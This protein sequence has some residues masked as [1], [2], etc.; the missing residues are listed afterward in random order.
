MAA[1]HLED[2]QELNERAEKLEQEL[3]EI[4]W[5]HM[6]ALEV[7][8]EESNK[9]QKVEQ[10]LSEVS[11]KLE[12]MDEATEN[13]LHLLRVFGKYLIENWC[14]FYDQIKRLD[15]HIFEAL[16]KFK[17]LP[18]NELEA[19]GLLWNWFEDYQI[20]FIK[21]MKDIVVIKDNKIVELRFG[22]VIL[23]IKGLP[24]LTKVQTL[25][26]DVRLFLCNILSVEVVDMIQDYC[27][28]RLFP[29]LLPLIEPKGV[30]VL[31]MRWLNLRETW[32]R[33]D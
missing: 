13:I 8:N 5:N 27:Q 1:G 31:K 33:Q 10:E 4:S 12:D 11:K 21:F 2:R 30:V 15:K 25:P 26:K 17:Y 22:D 18:V 6:W 14:I 16:T 29:H 7:S 24:P 23:K 28:L 20:Y 32:Y 19:L 9:R 3:K